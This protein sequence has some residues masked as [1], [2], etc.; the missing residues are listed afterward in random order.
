MSKRATKCLLKGVVL[1]THAG[2]VRL[3]HMQGCIKLTSSILKTMG[4]AIFPKKCLELVLDEVE[5]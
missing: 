2:R 5:V 3:S 1:L 4:K